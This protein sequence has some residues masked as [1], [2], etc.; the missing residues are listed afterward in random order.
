[1]IKCTQERGIMKF[2]GDYD[3]TVGNVVHERKK[4]VIEEYKLVMAILKG[5][6]WAFPVIEK[7]QTRKTTLLQ[8][9]MD[10]S[11]GVNYGR[12]VQQSQNNKNAGAPGA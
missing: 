11:I 1:M 8:N 12:P 2:A 3:Y 5:K 10:L 6:D 7:L 9:L 4:D